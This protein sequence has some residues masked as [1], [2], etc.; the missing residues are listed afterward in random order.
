MLACFAQACLL[1]SSILALLKHGYFAQACLL[2]SSMLA[3]LKHACFA[4][5]C[6]LA[7]LKHAY[8]A[9]L[10]SNSMQKMSANILLILSS[11]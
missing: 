10:K 1:C 2:C 9:R 11:K 3:L 5:A 8:S 4:Q 6:L 7:L